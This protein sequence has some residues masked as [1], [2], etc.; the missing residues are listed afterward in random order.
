MYRKKILIY[1]KLRDRKGDMTKKWYVEVSM[2]NPSTD[3][4]VR[5]R[6][7][8]E[9]GDTVNIN[10][11][12]LAGDRYQLAE[13]IISDLRMKISNGWTIF[14]DIT[15]CVYEDQLLYSTEARVFDKAV[16]STEN[17]NFWINRYITE[18]FPEMNLQDSTCA[19]YRSRFRMFGLWLKKK[20]MDEVHIK[21]ITNQV[22]ID[23]F[24]QLI[25]VQNL[26][27]RTYRSYED[28]LCAFFNFVRKKGGITENPIHDLPRNKIE[29]NMGAVR[30]SKED[31]E[32]L[33]PLLDER[34]PQLALAC[35]WEY[36]C[37]LRPGFE[38]RLM[39]VGDLDLRKG[40]AKVKVTWE[41]AKTL[42]T[43]YVAIPDVFLDYLLDFWKLDKYP[44]HFYVHGK[45][46]Q[47]GAEHLGKN[48][49]RFRFV[50]FRKELGLPTGNTFYSFKHSGATTLAERGVAIIDICDHLGHTS[51]QTTEKYLKRHG[52]YE[53]HIIRHNFPEI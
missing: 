52:A 3:E 35:R 21:K 27:K 46:R 51:V 10:S 9:E 43:R 17:Y 7:E 36:Y 22:A 38:I 30:I 28:L 25:G 32:R 31:L 12:S 29:K 5:K 13:K 49:L 2:R 40:I 50:P 8:C 33:M 39:K 19:T 53:S 42:R 6:Y 4:M 37:G 15:E 1:P 41:T 48:N 23:F 26:S 11:L 47:P 16:K 18:A 44:S 20:H 24:S 14:N 45:S 34:D